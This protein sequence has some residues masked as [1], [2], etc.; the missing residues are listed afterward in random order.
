MS[1]L[2]ATGLPTCQL[3]AYRFSH[4]RQRR[5]DVA[6]NARNTP[7]RPPFLPPRTGFG[8][9]PGKRFLSLFFS[10]PPSVPAAIEARAPLRL[11]PPLEPTH[12]RLP[13]RSSAIPHPHPRLVG[14]KAALDQPPLRL[15]LPKLLPPLHLLRS[16][17]THAL[18]FLEQQGAS[19]VADVQRTIP[20]AATH[21]EPC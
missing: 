10:F 15:I 21:L 4:P 17:F 11:L 1:I 2:T 8:C 14:C 7:S 3:P 5:P 19:M 16:A 18:H 12:H 6:A 13:N 20:S 9:S